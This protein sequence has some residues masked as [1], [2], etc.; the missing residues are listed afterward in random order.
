MNEK[1]DVSR[2]V[3]AGCWMLNGGISW[4]F[5]AQGRRIWYLMREVMKGR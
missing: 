3:G 5:F 2:R 4:D 1:K